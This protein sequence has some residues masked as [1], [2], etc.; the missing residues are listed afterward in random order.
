MAKTDSRNATTKL[1]FDCTVT[2]SFFFLGQELK[3]IRAHWQGVT[4]SSPSGY[5]RRLFG[6]PMQVVVPSV[7]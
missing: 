7:S 4:Y 2:H 1:D 5:R 3:T 6:I